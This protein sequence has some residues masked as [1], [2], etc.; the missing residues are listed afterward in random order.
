MQPMETEASNIPFG[1]SFEQQQ[2]TK[3][4]H[5]QSNKEEAADSFAWQHHQEVG[6]NILQEVK[7]VDLEEGTAEGQRRRRTEGEINGRLPSRKNP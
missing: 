2:N 7:L 4:N 6:N 1:T 5:D 3:A